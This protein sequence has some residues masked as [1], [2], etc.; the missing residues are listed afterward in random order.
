[1]APDPRLMMSIVCSLRNL[2]VAGAAAVA[3]A[4]PVLAQNGKSPDA[5]AKA[6]APAAQQSVD[7]DASRYCASVA[8]LIVNARVA[9]QT[10]ELNEAD[11]QLRQRIADL[12]KAEASARESIAR[13]DDMMKA[14]LNGVATIYAKMEPESAAKQIAAL[15]DRTAVAIL[16]KLK[17]GE[18]GAILG[19]MDADRADKLESLIADANVQGK[20]S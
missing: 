15:D 17:P 7:P 4:S 13:R 3:L 5:K 6:P 8:S 1:M 12:E 18:A 20:K 14:A 10:K 16:A 2:A 9:W 19:E 11:A